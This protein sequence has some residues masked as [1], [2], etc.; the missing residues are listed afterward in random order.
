MTLPMRPLPSG[1]ET[2][3]VADGAGVCEVRTAGRVSE[4]LEAN[5]GVCE[6]RTAGRVL[7][8]L[9]ANVGVCEVR[10]AGRAPEG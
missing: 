4:A 9:E 8:A 10:T 6:V 3:E 1:G 5:V 7:E 2:G